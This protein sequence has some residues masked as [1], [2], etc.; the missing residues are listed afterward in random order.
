MS[1]RQSPG[2][3]GSRGGM[4]PLLVGAATVLWGAAVVY[5]FRS[6]TLPLVLVLGLICGYAVHRFFLNQPDDAV[7]AMLDA[8]R[9]LRGGDYTGSAGES[10]SEIPVPLASGLNELAGWLQHRRDC[11]NSLAPR[12]AQLAQQ[13][14]RL[15]AG[16][17]EAS[18]KRELS[19]N[20]LTELRAAVEQVTASS[21]QAA[22]AS[23]RADE[24]GD[25]GKVAM[26]EA[27]GA[28][29]RLNRELRDARAAV[30]QLDEFTGTI[31]GV[32]DVI[33]GIADQT[34]MLA[35]NAAI[36]AARAGEQGRG[37]AVVADEVRS[38]A[39][40]TQQSTKEI[41]S[42]VESVRERARA[43]VDVVVEGDNQAR[44]CEQL[45]ENACVALGGV[46]GE[47]AGIRGL[48]TTIEGFADQQSNVVGRLAGCLSVA[49]QTDRVGVPGEE[50]RE[51]VS[52]L[53]G[54]AGELLETAN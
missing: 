29:D 15:Q 50:L 39:A 27:L 26:T 8:L 40:K 52:A 17:A 22:Q 42:M 13:A 51:L 9:R 19:E 4:R 54:L 16:G 45:I 28:I 44:V 30:Q 1:T 36:E 47:I 37:F 32:L 11:M 48:N 2:G 24:V 12:V 34:N 6:E 14:R 18:S 33:R 3:G 20:A 5:A 49:A 43:V 10:G 38:L 35:L 46:A 21:A 7:P 41:Q 23:R 53:D 31:G 25:E